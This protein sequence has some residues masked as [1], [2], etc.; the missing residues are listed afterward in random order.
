MPRFI[1]LTNYD[2]FEQFAAELDRAR[3]PMRFAYCE[4]FQAFERSREL[5]KD[6]ERAGDWYSGRGN[7]EEANALHNEAYTYDVQAEMFASIAVLFADDLLRRFHQ[8]LF[9]KA[10]TLDR[11]FG[12]VHNG[13][14]L[15]TILQAG[16]N[17]IRH[18][19]SWADNLTFPY[20]QDDTNLSNDAKRAL[21]NIRVIEK[22]FGSFGGPWNRPPSWDI[23]F[24]MNAGEDFKPEENYDNFEQAIVIA[25]LNMAQEH[26]QEA[27]AELKAAVDSIR[28][29]DEA[30]PEV[31]EP[32]C[33]RVPKR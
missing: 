17:A 8:Q 24:T 3:E 13:V 4:A 14:A 18:V 10:P 20:P 16:G 5:L 19:S 7:Q 12:K 1:E 25:A 2:R 32:G 31:V 28:R 33:G 22:A 11:G 9:G 21:A 27:L 23:L 29:A 15:S 6:S 30:A 26:S